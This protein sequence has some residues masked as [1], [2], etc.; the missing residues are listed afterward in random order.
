MLVTSK[1]AQLGQHLCSDAILREHSLDRVLN[2]ELGVA[3]ALQLK[4]TV[5]LAANKDLPI[6]LFAEDGFSS[7]K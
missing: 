4:G 2:D 3:L 7:K 1:H 5:A 6:M